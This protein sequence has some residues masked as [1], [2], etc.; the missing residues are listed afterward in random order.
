V[1]LFQNI[2]SDLFPG[3]TVPDQDHGELERAILH[4]LHSRGLQAPETYVTKVFCSVVGAVRCV[5]VV[6][7][8]H[9]RALEQHAVRA[10]IER[11]AMM[12]AATLEQV[13]RTRLPAV[14][15]QSHSPP[16]ARLRLVARRSSSCTTLWMYGLASCWWGPP[17][18]A[19]PHATPLCRAR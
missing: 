7:V 6:E 15:V 19:R 17:A 4:V 11:R 12:A 9:A 18:E 13:K 1:E 3:V 8:L 14:C 5:A 2:I 16:P 10:R